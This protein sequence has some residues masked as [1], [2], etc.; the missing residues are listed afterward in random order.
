MP[1][2][3]LSSQINYNPS[4]IGLMP[5]EDSKKLYI[6]NV[7]NPISIRLLAFSELMSADLQYD[8]IN[9]A[10]ALATDILLTQNNKKAIRFFNEKLQNNQ[11]I[12]NDKF[13]GVKD[14]HFVPVKLR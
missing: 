14:S 5:Q 10:T 9:Y 12:Y 8:W 1:L 4:L 13:Y 7:I 2:A 6:V 3:F 11:V